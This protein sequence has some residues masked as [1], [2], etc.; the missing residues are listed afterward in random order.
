MMPPVQD[1]FE[2]GTVPANPGSAERSQW[3]GEYHEQEEEEGEGSEERIAA[4]VVGKYMCP[5]E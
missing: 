1:P 5:R 2:E 4:S 3:P